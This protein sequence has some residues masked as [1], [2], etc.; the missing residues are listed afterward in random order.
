MKVVKTASGNQ[1]KMSRSEWEKIGRT[2]GWDDTV[3]MGKLDDPNDWRYDIFKDSIMGGQNE[4]GPWYKEAYFV[5]AIN[6]AGNR[7]QHG[8]PFDSEEACQQAID[9]MPPEPNLEN[10]WFQLPPVYGSK[11][12]SQEEPHRVEEERRQDQGGF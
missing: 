11:V 9:N 12:W 6:D 3:N 8:N 4:D 2:A 10:G 1:L 7:Y 5:V